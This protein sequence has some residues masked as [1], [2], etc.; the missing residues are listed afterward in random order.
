MMKI[1]YHWENVLVNVPCESHNE[2]R[3]KKV[4]KD[5]DYDFEFI[6]K[7]NDMV[8]YLMPYPLTKED[9]NKNEQEIRDT[10]L[11]NFFMTKALSFLIVD[12]SRSIDLD[13][14][15]NDEYFVEFLKERYEEQAYEEWEESNEEY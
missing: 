3:T 14:L 7:V 2:P 4:L 5:I 6:V 12:C 11:A 13:D 15:E 9:K 10:A 8:D 1:R